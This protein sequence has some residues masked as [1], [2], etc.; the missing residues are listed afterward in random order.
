M[1]HVYAVS[2]VHNET[3]ICGVTRYGIGQASFLQNRL[4]GVRGIR[5]VQSLCALT[6]CMVQ[7][8]W[9]ETESFFFSFGV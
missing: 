1:K 8:L 7:Y 5:R 4:H 3:E 2:S 6:P 9:W